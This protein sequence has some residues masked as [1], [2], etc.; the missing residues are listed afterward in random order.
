M[1]YSGKLNIQPTVHFSQF[2]LH[3]IDRLSDVVAFCFCTCLNC[4]D[5]SIL[6]LSCKQMSKTS[7]VTSCLV[8]RAHLRHKHTFTFESVV[9]TGESDQLSVSG[10]VSVSTV[11]EQS[12]CEDS[13][14]TDRMCSSASMSQTLLQSAV[15]NCNLDN[16]RNP[17]NSAAVTDSVNVASCNDLLSSSAVLPS[18]V[19]ANADFNVPW[20]VSNDH[21]TSKRQLAATAVHPASCN[22]PVHTGLPVLEVGSFSSRTLPFQVM[23]YHLYLSML[24]CVCRILIEI[25]YLC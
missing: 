24:M 16:P 12:V 6:V 8:P 25:T 19:C 13:S 20:P 3:D 11:S 9:L 22:L 23:F 1:C 21:R 15:H 10:A 2:A 5:W 4:C 17:L 14:S 18:Q 7:V